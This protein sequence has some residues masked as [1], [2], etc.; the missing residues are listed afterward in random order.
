M[1][2]LHDSIKANPDTIRAIIQIHPL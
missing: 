1:F 2:S